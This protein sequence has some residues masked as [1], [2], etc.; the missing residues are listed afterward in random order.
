VSVQPIPRTPPHAAERRAL[1]A[2]VAATLLWGGTFVAIRDAV[3]AVPPATL[4]AWRF[5]AAGLL[6]ALVLLVRRRRPARHDVAGGVLSG[7]LMVGGFYLQARG[8]RSTAAGTSAFLTCGGTLLA[9]FWAWPLLRQRPGGRLVAG[10]ALAMAGAALLSLRAGFALGTGE[11]LTLVGAALFALQIVA[12]ARFAAA[13]DPVALVCVQSFTAA[14]VLLPF[15]GS[16]LAA[17][18]LFVGA[19]R[20]RFVYLAVAGSTLAPL[21][22]VVAQRTLP[23]GRV[24][25]LFALE[26]VFA[27]LFAL[28]LGGER[29]GA[30]WWA[31]AALIL[32]AVVLVEWRPEDPAPGAGAGAG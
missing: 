5:A 3:A 30:H 13:A 24:G 18:G 22:Q 20:W 32:A 2:M 19:D 29:F 10:I 8:L 14:A 26:P 25:L 9:A 23:A 31:G 4:V 21:L 17:A 1:A 16:P 27:L 7:L 11:M 28:T 6:F 12:V 15:A